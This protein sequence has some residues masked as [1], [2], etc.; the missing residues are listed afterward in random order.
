MMDAY[1]L[2]EAHDREQS[3]K[4]ERLPKCFCCGEPI[5]QEMAVCL[6]GFGYLCDDCIK[7]NMEDVTNDDY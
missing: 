1:Y 3:K 6:D 2:W 4:L 5:Q 7:N